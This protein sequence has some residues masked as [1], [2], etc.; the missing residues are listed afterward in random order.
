MTKFWPAVV[1]IANYFIPFF[2][3]SLFMMVMVMEKHVEGDGH[4][5]VDFYLL[6]V[7]VSNY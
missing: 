7:F 1:S 4:G 3:S 5:F 2:S 6:T